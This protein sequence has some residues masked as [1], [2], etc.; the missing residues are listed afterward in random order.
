MRHQLCAL[1]LAAVLDARDLKAA[2]GDKDV[3]IVDPAEDLAD[4]VDP[5]TED[6]PIEPAAPTE[7]VDETSGSIRTSTNIVQLD[8]W[9][10]S[11]NVKED[12][13]SAWVVIFYSQECPFSRQVEPHFY[14]IALKCSSQTEKQVKFGAVEAN[15]ERF[16]TWDNGITETPSVLTKGFAEDSS[17]GNKVY[18]GQVE[19]MELIDMLD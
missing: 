4:Q 1:V 11:A 17:I 7:P 6:E 2:K 10:F 18:S 9:N 19:F 8:N 14:D 5:V 13:E 16:L 12:M 15:V 3:M